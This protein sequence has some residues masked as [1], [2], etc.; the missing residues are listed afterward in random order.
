MPIL[1]IDENEYN[2]LKGVADLAAAI[3]ANPEGRKLLEQAHRTVNPK[4]PAPT[5]EN[6]SRMAEP[7]QALQKQLSDVASMV[8]DRFDKDETDKKLD[9]IKRQQDEAFDR[10]VNNSGYRPE[11]IEA[12]KKIMTEKGILDVEVAASYFERISPPQAPVTPTGSNA[13]NF[14][15]AFTA[16][17]S[18]KALQELLQSQGNSETA[19]NKLIAES[20]NDA[21]KTPTRR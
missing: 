16:P 8:K 20:L 4:A 5:L 2:R 18:D 14:I 1:E 19:L 21:R 7:I 11:G 9:A 17:E 15:E 13:V 6:E 10:L 3:H 12:V